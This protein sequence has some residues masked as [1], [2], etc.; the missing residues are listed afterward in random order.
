MDLSIELENE[1]IKL[2][3]AAD[4]FLLFFVCYTILLLY[5]AVPTIFCYLVILLFSYL[6]I[7]IEF[8]F[9]FLAIKSLDRK[10]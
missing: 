6:V 3:S 4:N 8:K 10:Y 2:A 5:I 9:K 1:L 7:K